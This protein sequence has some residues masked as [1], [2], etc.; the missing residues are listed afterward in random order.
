MTLT[1]TQKETAQ[2]IVQIFETGKLGTKAA[3]SVVTLLKGDTGGLTYGKHQTTINSGNLYLMIKTYID[4]PK[5]LYRD[6]FTDYMAPLRVKSSQLA[7]NTAFKTL[8]K[9]AGTDPVMQETQD[10]FFDRV[11]WQPALAQA[12]AWGFTN[13]L[14]VA[15]IYD[16]FIHGSFRLIKDRTIASNGQPSSTNEKKWI[17]AYNKNRKSW[18]GNHSNTLLRKTIY[19]QEAFEALI[20]NNAWSLPIPVT[21]RGVL[22]NAEKLGVVL[23]DDGSDKEIVEDISVPEDPDD[24]ILL[25]VHGHLMRGAD[26]VRLQTRLKELGFVV[27]VIDGIFGSQTDIAVH[28]FQR[29]KG[30][31]SDGIVGP[32]TRAALG[33]N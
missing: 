23:E 10:S 29:M 2:A 11:Y 16:S 28:A 6:K 14:S 31:V 33:L 15:I 1:E 24:R 3:Y 30:L 22:I 26:V 4:N 12:E 9:E 7:S 13:P 25:F 17:A 21:V 32:V 20:K 19:R 27:G 5:A 18:L 8:L